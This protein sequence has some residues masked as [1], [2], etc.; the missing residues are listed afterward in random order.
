[1]TNAQEATRRDATPPHAAAGKSYEAMRFQKYKYKLFSLK[2]FKK[3]KIESVF[4]VKGVGPRVKWI[5]Y[6]C[7][8]F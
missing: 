2:C 1:M 8:S 7:Y 3:R 4:Q 5:I 6:I